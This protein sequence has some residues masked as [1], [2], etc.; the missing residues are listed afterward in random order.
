[1]TKPDPKPDPEVP[2]GFTE[3]SAWDC[4]DGCDLQEDNGG[5]LYECGDC[6]TRYNRDNSADG[7]SHRC[8]DCNKFGA[9]TGETACIECGSAAANE[10]AALQCDECSELVTPDD[11]AEH[12]KECALTVPAEEEPKADAK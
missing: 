5:V 8:P 3:V 9:K 12:R 2:P 4:E 1:M 7:G 11:A 10:T 6:G